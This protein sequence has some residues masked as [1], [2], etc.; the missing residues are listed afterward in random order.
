MLNTIVMK[1]LKELQEKYFKKEGVI[2]FRLWAFV[3][4]TLE[5]YDD[6]VEEKVEMLYGKVIDFYDSIWMET[7]ATDEERKDI[8]KII[9]V[10]TFLRIK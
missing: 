8:Q 7:K 3:T 6:P 4:M 1:E 5:L 2:A 9:D 10:L